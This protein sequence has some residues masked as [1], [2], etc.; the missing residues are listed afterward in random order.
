MEERWEKLAV[1]VEGGRGGGWG[2]RAG[3]GNSDGTVP[4]LNSHSVKEGEREGGEREE[5]REGR[6]RGKKVR[7]GER[8]R[9]NGGAKVREGG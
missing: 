2:E 6:G 9:R 3:E 1:K 7:E 5:G 8:R 4:Q